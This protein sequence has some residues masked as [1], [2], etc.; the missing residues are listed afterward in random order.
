M[1]ENS[2]GKAERKEFMPQTDTD[3]LTLIYAERYKVCKR[4]LC[5]RRGGFV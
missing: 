4:I 5:V 2:K 3:S 1:N